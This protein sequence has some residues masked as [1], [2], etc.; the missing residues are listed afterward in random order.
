MQLMMGHYDTTDSPKAQYICVV[1]ELEF[2][3]L[4]RYMA[5]SLPS[6][7]QAE[8]QLVLLVR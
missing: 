5:G 8:V 3:T 2:S 4:S 7:L 1:T 6:R